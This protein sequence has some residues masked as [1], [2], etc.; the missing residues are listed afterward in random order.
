MYQG[1]KV[2]DGGNNLYGFAVQDQDVSAY[3]L[4]ADLGLDLGKAR[5]TY[6]GWYASGDDD[7]TDGDI[8][9]FMATDVDETASIVLMEG[10]Y[11]NDNYFTESYYILDKG[12]IF[13]KVALD[14][15][16]TEKTKLGGAVLYMMTAEDLPNGED[17]LGT[18]LDAYISHKLY[19]NLEVA[20]NF[21]YLFSDKGMDYFAENNDAGNIYRSTAR[22]RYT[23]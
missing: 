1:G 12:M 15:K 9:N 7:P 14:Y 17:K 4:H 22:V 13:N 6:T 16:A 3:F 2:D 11:T 10:G 20:V 8:H 5:F 21:G 23:F 18:E 19:P